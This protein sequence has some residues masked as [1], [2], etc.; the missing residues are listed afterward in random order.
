MESIQSAVLYL[1]GVGGG[2]MLLILLRRPL[3]FVLK[4]AL[5]G[6]AG[7]AFLAVF[8]LAA[9][10]LGLS[11]PLNPITGLACGLLGAPGLATLLLLQTVAL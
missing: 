6:V 8:N 10:W 11:L 1:F 9:G 5:R 3:S 2:L 4:I 7:L